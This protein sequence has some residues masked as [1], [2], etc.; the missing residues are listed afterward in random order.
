MKYLL[1]TNR[2]Q[3]REITND[4]YDSL[5]AI[6]CDEQTMAYYPKPYDEEGVMRWIDWC[7]TS[8]EKNGFGLWAVELLDGTFIGDCGISLQNIDGNEVFEIGYHINRQYW[9]N[10][11]ATEAARA[12]KKY[13]FEHTKNNEIYSY[14]NSNNCSSIAVAISNGMHFVKTYEI[15]GV[16]HDVYCIT[17]KQYELERIYY[18]DSKKENYYI[19]KHA[20][21]GFSNKEIIIDALDGIRCSCDGLIVGKYVKFLDEIIDFHKDTLYLDGGLILLDNDIEESD[22]CNYDMEHQLSIK[23]YLDNDE[24]SIDRWNSF[25][26]KFENKY[27]NFRIIKQ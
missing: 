1:K 3:L 18:V 27:L 15:D 21:Y 26:K 4:D 13:F 19:L 6:I 16:N 22:K 9:K 17:R 12:C 23:A 5:K 7:K 24:A 10:G 11:Y 2:L 14:M 8:Y 25:L 20:T